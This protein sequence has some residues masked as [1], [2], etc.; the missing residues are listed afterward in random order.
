MIEK[1]PRIG[2]RIRCEK[3]VHLEVRRSCLEFAKWLRNEFNFPIRVVV[4]LKKA[5]QIKAIDKEMVSATFLG[6]YDKNE[7]PFIRV[8]TGDYEELVMERGE[9]S[10]IFAILN[11]MAHEIIHYHQWL[12]D[13]DF[14]EEQAEI[15]AEIESIKLVDEYYGYS[16]INEIIEHQKVFTIENEEGIPTTTNDNGEESMPFWSSELRTEV[17]IKNVNFYREYHPL[18]ISL[19]DFISNWLPKLQKDALVLGANLKGD[20]LIGTDWNPKELLEEIKNKLDTK[21]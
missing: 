6:P 14:D 10:A 5:K 21:E 17:I 20:K 2:L 9:G 12:K 8:A 15:E 18:E 13:P 19:E 4:Y 3:G 16:F 11:C 7:E 1:N